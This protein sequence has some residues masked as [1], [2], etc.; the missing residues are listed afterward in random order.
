MKLVAPAVVG[1]RGFT[2]AARR[3]VVSIQDRAPGRRTP[4]TG[5]FPSDYPGAEIP[6]PVGSCL[7]TKPPYLPIYVGL[8]IS[9]GRRRRGDPDL[10][11]A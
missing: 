11:L 7:E 5:G 2:A 8:A 4:D 3:L 9:A 1:Y 6:G 10:A